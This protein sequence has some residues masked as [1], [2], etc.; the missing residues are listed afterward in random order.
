M[1]ELYELA[2]RTDCD[3]LQRLQSLDVFI[4]PV[5]APDD[6]D[7]NNR[8]TAW[9]FD[10]NRDRG[11]FYMPENRALIDAITRYP[12]LFFID[13][14]QQSSGYFFPP[15]QDAAL[16]EISHPA[17]DA[18]QN[19]IGPA[20]QNAFN[21]QTGQ[22]RNYNTYDLFVPEYGDT[23]PSL[24]MGG[25]GMTYEKG[26]NESYGKQVYDHYLAMDTTV[27][28]VAQE[29][30]SL[31]ASWI[32][33]W[34]QAVDQGKT[35]T[36]QDNTQV[37]PP[38]VDQ[39]EIGQSS[40]D[41][42]PNTSV[43]GYYYLPG[44]HSGDVAQ[45]IKDL[46]YVG[47][48]VYKL[49]KAVTVPGAH[50]FGNFNI[51]AAPGQ[52]SPDLTAT[53]T[54]P[55]G[56]LYIPLSQGTKHWIQ[57][58]LGENPYLPF[59]YFY[60]EVTW[61]YSLLRGF[62]GDGFLTQQLPGGTKMTQ[63]GDP[64]ARTAPAR[65]Q[66]VYAFNTD[67][68]AGLAMVNQ[69]LGQGATVAR[70]AAAFDAAGQHF[71][72]GAALV[73]GS[74]ID[75]ATLTADASKWETPVSGLSGYPVAHLAIG[76]PKIAIYTG[77]TTVPTNP[78]IHGTGDGY[79][80]TSTYCEAMFDLT[81]KEG[82]PTSAIG[83]LTSTDLSNG[84]LQ[85]SSY[86]VLIDPGSTISATTPTGTA[87]TP[88]AAVQAFINGGGTFL[89]TSNGGAT[90]ARNAGVTALNTNTIAGISTPGST[91]D[92]SWNTADPAG[93]GLDAGGWVYRESNNDPVFD[94]AT[95]AGNGSTVPAAT[96]VAT[97]SPAATAAG[98]PF[99]N[100]YGYEIN[101][102]ANLPGR[103]RWLTSRSLRSRDHARLRPVVPGL[104][105]GRGAAGTERD[106]L[107]DRNGYPRRTDV[108]RA[109]P[110]RCA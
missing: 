16:N 20:I 29:K 10:P 61:S 62:A 14:H 70:A 66:P 11:T 32:P 87:G 60:D 91:F 95:L 31:A 75:L 53:V 50:Q 26:N 104:D 110:G 103:P 106:L 72:T 58:V 45:T 30:D 25:A 22:Y 28:V 109:R 38:V 88:A 42:E 93:W 13:A 81:Q 76:L 65:S 1:K 69:L 59:N 4:Q 46:Q 101:A 82:F 55:A 9:D 90:S 100:C 107:P 36:V 2:A 33:Q 64:G 94:P 78:A 44:Q 12:G 56:T 7:H 19:V 98:R 40:I 80:T 67:S 92:A 41:Q 18:I 108:G 37:S 52:G 102:N 71:D 43:C 77:G 8:T 21:D 54:L 35:C 23:V 86:T 48:K 97:Y 49:T 39:Y 84:V 74:S 47:V 73:D 3:N 89:G 57:A 15:D 105:H 99:G 24:L 79:C 6:R 68:M 17:L 96:A 85:S 5:T 34:P 63:I 83:Q 51:N 27:N